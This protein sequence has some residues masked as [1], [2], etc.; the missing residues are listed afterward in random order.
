MGVK[1]FLDSF[2]L[3]FHMACKNSPLVPLNVFDFVRMKFG[4][5]CDIY[6]S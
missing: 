1:G 3:S 4:N 6:E 5:V 2:L